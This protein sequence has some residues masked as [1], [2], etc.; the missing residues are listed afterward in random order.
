MMKRLLAAVIGV[1]AGAVLFGAY[2]ALLKSGIQIRPDLTLAAAAA[3]VFAS[4]VAVFALIAM[5]RPA[6]RGSRA[7]LLLNE[8]PATEF[9]FPFRGDSMAQIT[10]RPEMSLGESLARFGETFKRPPEEMTKDI[11][12]TIKGSR[13][14]PFATV[15]LQ[16]L[17][18][19][20]KPFKLTHVLLTGDKD[21]FIGYIPG[22]RALK[23]FTA[24]DAAEKVTKFIVKVV[25]NPGDSRIL[26]DIGGASRLDTISETD[27]ARRAEAQL[28]ADESA[29][30]LVVHKH[31][32]PVGYISKVDVLRLNAGRP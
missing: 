20:L 9:V 24:D 26:R 8:E 4:A 31:L 17:F 25:D 30:G 14:A 22:K 10:A 12:L 15:T 19:T 1:G 16:Q 18:L 32:K 13:R 6:F 7:T 29:Q 21:E 28:W 2:A 23:E 3:I 11:T 5:D 27:D